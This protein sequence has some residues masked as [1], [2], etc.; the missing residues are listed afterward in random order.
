VS[1][2]DG[3]GKV[4]VS[5]AT[6]ERALPYRRALVA[7]GVPEAAIQVVTPA[8]RGQARLLA[9]R[10]AGLLLCGGEDVEPSRYGEAELPGAGVETLPERDATEWELLA[11]ARQAGVPVLAVCRG[12]QVVNVF[13]GGSLWQD[14]PSQR[15]GEVEH[16]L[17]EPRDTLAHP[18]LAT[19]APH[20]LAE[21]LAR[22]EARVN[23]RHHQGVKRLAPGLLPLAHASDGLIEALA[24]PLE[25]GWLAAV[26]WHPENL[27]ALPLQ[28]ELWRLFAAAVA[29][30]AGVPSGAAR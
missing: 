12:L 19:D 14:L 29:A 6:A 25:E 1:G 21:L 18:V 22:G 8:E 13:R 7:G 28:L 11:G 30:P 3:R 9:A 16:W 20:P 2:G 17:A 15:G 27:L 5:V 26:Q 4:L 24:L 23:S 10:A